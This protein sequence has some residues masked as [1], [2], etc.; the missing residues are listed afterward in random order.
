MNALTSIT[1]A[2]SSRN[3]G[4]HLT[5]AE[6]KDVALAIGGLI[7]KSQHDEDGRIHLNPIIQ[8]LSDALGKPCAL[9]HFSSKRREMME[10]LAMYY[11]KN[12][13]DIYKSQAGRYS[14]GTWSVFKFYLS[15]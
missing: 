10:R 9:N 13:D 12:V 7:T 14:S 5:A 1:K 4:A 8:Q 15:I 3:R 6:A 11:N 2:S